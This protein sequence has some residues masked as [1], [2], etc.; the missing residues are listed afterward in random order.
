MLR[1]TTR[2]D[3]ILALVVRHPGI[4]VPKLAEMLE[5]EPSG[6]L[7]SVGRRTQA[8]T[9]PR[10]KTVPT[11]AQRSA[12]PPPQRSARA[13]RRNARQ[14]RARARRNAR[15]RG[16]LARSDRRALRVLPGA[17][18]VDRAQWTPY[19]PDRGAR[20]AQGRAVGQVRSFSN[21]PVTRRVQAAGRALVVHAARAPRPDGKRTPARRAHARGLGSV[22][23]LRRS[24]VR[25]GLGAGVGGGAFPTRR[26]RLRS[27]RLAPLSVGRTHDHVLQLPDQHEATDP[28]G[29]RALQPSP[30]NLANPGRE[31]VTPAT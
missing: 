2:Q 9:T 26:G 28:S 24:F 15:Q 20:A 1:P 6:S 10:K 12:R 13:R 16:R 21:A 19:A 14:R 4:T 23:L 11:S 25:A 5:V 7:Y 8:S 27:V 29:V 18:R 17:E 31:S 3:R 22:T 30:S